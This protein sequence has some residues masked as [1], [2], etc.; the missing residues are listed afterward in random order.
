MFTPDRNTVGSRTLTTP[1][2]HLTLIGLSTRWRAPLPSRL[3]VFTSCGPTFLPTPPPLLPSCLPIFLF[4]HYRGSDFVTGFEEPDSALALLRSLRPRLPPRAFSK[5]KFLRELRS[6][7]FA[8]EL[9]SVLF[10]R[11]L[12]SVLFT[13]LT[14]VLRPVPPSLREHP[15]M[16]SAFHSLQHRFGAPRRHLPLPASQWPP[17]RTKR[18]HWHN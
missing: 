17:R 16:R 12:Y 3:L 9:R 10:A 14:A 1:R 8:R 7:A 18:R 4:F 2:P 15:P 6:G 5:R 11:A 13:A